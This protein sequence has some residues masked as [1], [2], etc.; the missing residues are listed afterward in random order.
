MHAIQLL[1]TLLIALGSTQAPAEML[2]PG[3]V[4][5]GNEKLDTAFNRLY[6]LAHN[7]KC[8]S[9][10]ESYE[11]IVPLI[12]EAIEEDPYL[13]PN[14]IMKIPYNYP[15][16]EFFLLSL[17]EYQIAKILAY[18]KVQE[19]ETGRDLTITP[20][21]MHEFALNDATFR[22][23]IKGEAVPRDV[24]TFSYEQKSDGSIEK[25][26]R[27]VSNYEGLYDGKMT[28]LVR[29]KVFVEWSMQELPFGGFVV[30]IND[31]ENNETLTLE[32]A[33]KVVEDGK[34]AQWT[35]IDTKKGFEFWD[36]FTGFCDD[37]KHY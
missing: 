28:W 37:P 8:T 5:S 20:L 25:T 21:E 26:V 32:L 23:T 27:W 19:A 3:L 12:T 34:P 10:Y 15:V 4:S 7:K 11:Y 14:Y 31:T 2:V 16:S 30:V 22:R 18:E 6:K 9:I 17:Y 33:K 29:K 36:Y 1:F 35:L 24:L 13:V